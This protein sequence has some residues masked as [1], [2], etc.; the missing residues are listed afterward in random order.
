MGAIASAYVEIGADDKPFRE[1]LKDLAYEGKRLS[2]NIRQGL[3]EAFSAENVGAF[4]GALTGS[5]DA[6]WAAASLISAGFGKAIVAVSAVTAAAAATALALDAVFSRDDDQKFADSVAGLTSG[7]RGLAEEIKYTDTKIKA[8]IERDAT[9]GGGG[10]LDVWNS[11]T[12]EG[13]KALGERILGVETMT[14]QI[15][16]NM[17]NAVT[18]SKLFADNLVRGALAGKEQS[19]Q[20]K[21]AE[22][23]AGLILSAPEKEI[24]RQNATAFQ[25][26]LDVT[27]GGISA[28]RLLKFFR[29]N[30]SELQ[31]GQSPMEAAQAALGALMDGSAEAAEKF[32]H[33]F[34]LAEEKAKLAVD[35]WMKAIPAT[36]ELAKLEEARIARTKEFAD[37]QIKRQQRETEQAARDL[38]R[39]EEQRGSMEERLAQFQ[40]DRADRLAGAFQFAGIKE[41]RDRLFMAAQDAKKDE[42]TASKMQ[43]EIDRVVKALYSLKLKW[44]MN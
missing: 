43:G 27:G 3:Q 15:A 30:P 18:A 6:G 1:K 33:L 2:F 23:M 29:E 11:K 21:G 22:A 10:W 8:I 31:A 4:V 5:G 12:R 36:N 9:G 14:S 26:A 41:A 34:G 32:G 25:R 19:Y 44:E 16:R 24:Q 37:A 42:L 7:F 35:E 13:W 40:Q 39:L 38:T 20:K 17:N 28:Q